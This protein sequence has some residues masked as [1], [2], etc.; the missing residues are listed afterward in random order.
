[1]NSKAQLRWNVVEAV[2]LSADVKM[3]LLLRLGPKLNGSGE[4]LITSDRFRD[5]ARN[6]EDCLEKLRNWVAVAA[7]KPKLRKKTKP[8]RSVREKNKTNKRRHAAKKNA[9]RRPE[10]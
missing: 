7:R 1:V 8:S 5:Q 9:R 6:R 3:Q 10:Y 2:G 4:L